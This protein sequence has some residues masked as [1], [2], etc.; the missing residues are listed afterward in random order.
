MPNQYLLTAALPRMKIPTWSGSSPV[1]LIILARKSLES[2]AGSNVVAHADT[3]DCG[4]SI[5]ESV[6]DAL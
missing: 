3:D 4:G 2:N 5:N 6:T 1:L